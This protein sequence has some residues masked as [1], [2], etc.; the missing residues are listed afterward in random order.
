[1][2]NVLITYPDKTVEVRSLPDQFRHFK[3]EEIGFQTWFY[4]NLLY[5]QEEVPTRFATYK[6]TDLEL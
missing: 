6:L 4:Y 1:M 5:L 2:K 3:D